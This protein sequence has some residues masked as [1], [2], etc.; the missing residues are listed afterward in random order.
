MKKIALFSLL[1]MLTCSSSWAQDKT[2]T[3]KERTIFLWGHVK[4]SFTRS[5]IV[6]VKITLMR[7]DST[8]IDTMTVDYFDKDSPQMDS[9]YKFEIP[10]RPQK[11]IIK[12]EQPDYKTTFIN[13]EIKYVARNTYFDAPWHLMKKA[14][15]EVEHSH[16]LKEVV[17]K[18]TQVK[19][20][21]KGDTLVYN[22]D[23]F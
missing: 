15:K 6:D 17:V 4:D 18:A 1:C 12:A 8:V 14:E 7:P 13:Y 19:L 21:Y 2:V 23:A 5:G 16:T 3:P 11:F 10:A 22:A 9:Y 20:V